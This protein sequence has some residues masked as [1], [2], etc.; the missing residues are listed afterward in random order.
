MRNLLLAVAPFFVVASVTSAQQVERMVIV[1][2]TVAG[3]ATALPVGLVL[4]PSGEKLYC[5]GYYGWTAVLDCASNSITKDIPVTAP[6]QC[7]TTGPVWSH[8]Y[9]K[10]YIPTAIGITIV[11][12]VT[13][14]ITTTLHIPRE[15][16]GLYYSACG[17]AF[18]DS[19]NCLV[20]AD[21]DSFR[22][23]V[24]DGSSDT[25][26]ARLPV[27]RMPFPV[28]WNSLNNRYYVLHN[29]PP[30]NNSWFL[31][32]FDA[33]ADTV[34]DSFPLGV[35]NRRG[36]AE[37][38][39]TLN[40]LYFGS[41]DSIVVIDCSADTV[42]KRLPFG[43]NELVWSSRTNKLYCLYWQGD[44]ARVI[45]CDNDTL[46]RSIRGLP[47][48]SCPAV[49]G[50]SVNKLFVLSDSTVAIIDCA[51]DSLVAELPID[52][53]DIVW[54]EPRQCAHVATRTGVVTIDGISHQ[55]LGRR[56]TGIEDK[57]GFLYNPLVG[58][59]YVRSLRRGGPGEPDLAE[60]IVIDGATGRFIKRF[61]VGFTEWDE[62]RLCLDPTGT[63]LYCPN[64]ED[65]TI[66][67]IDCA[68]DTVVKTINVSPEPFMLTV[69]PEY[70][71][72]YCSHITCPG[73]A[74]S[75]ID[76]RTDSL[77][78]VVELPGDGA[79]Y[80]VWF[81]DANKVYVQGYWSDVIW[82]IDGTTNRLL[83]VISGFRGWLSTPA[84][85]DPERKRLYV[86]VANWGMG[87][88]ILYSIDATA[89]T[90]LRSYTPSDSLRTATGA[91]LNP[92]TK[93]LYFLAGYG[94][95]CR[96]VIG[97]FD[98][99]QDT[100]VRVIFPPQVD[101]NLCGQAGEAQPVSHPT[102][103]LVY[104]PC[105][106]TYHYQT[107][108]IIDGG[109]VVIDCV[110]DSIVAMA[111]YPIPDPEPCATDMWFDTTSGLI[112]VDGI[113]RIYV[114][115]TAPPGVNGPLPPRNPE[116]RLV[117]F[118]NPMEHR[119]T[120][121]ASGLLEDT[122]MLNIFDRTGRR[123][124]SLAALSPRLSRVVWHWDGKDEL[125]REVPAG[126]YFLYHK[127]DSNTTSAKVVKLR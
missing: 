75:V 90:I 62:S 89:D 21:P 82:V 80:P 93:K 87:V 1:S 102:R 55:I 98:C 126:I 18:N 91:V 45:D 25:V 37:Y 99:A 56:S 108:A 96:D 121:H 30:H 72:L 69:N 64:S 88:P 40:K 9:N 53:N 107:G 31:T 28:V 117:C 73:A 47:G 100:F 116:V 125:G 35:W 81:A 95:S 36:T 24:I 86:T 66:S 122:A 39:P 109:V 119:L 2:D 76:C 77:I 101:A 104:F 34:L 58:K 50:P 106:G 33:R 48:R 49:Y 6:A 19:E 111:R 10:A 54:N 44:S 46:L 124:R 42:C 12:G 5:Q 118:P 27:T 105:H 4:S 20:A 57:F 52:G 41:G 71:R 120:V 112:Y 16:R 11:D 113:S 115:G 26:R 14:S 63:K 84:I 23:L 127:T 22:I 67:V 114:V 74:L 8:T 68:L 79:A 60:I 83:T 51:G 43:A 59:F 94:H 38:V 7:P 97:V 15:Q 103:P 65:G 110:L 17:M 78:T 32:V 13:D 70:N 29:L 123:V 61:P 3:G 85:C 92:S